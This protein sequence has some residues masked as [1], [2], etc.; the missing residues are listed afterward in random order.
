MEQ[1]IIGLFQEM[2][3]LTIALLSAGMLLCIF[4][5]FVPKVGLTG[6]LGIA[7]LCTGMSSYYIDGFKLNQLLGMLSIIALLLAVFIVIE[8]ILEAKG[9]IKNPNR[10]KLR[11]YQD[12][13]KHLNEL[14][15]SIGKAVTNIDLGGTIEIDGKLYY[16]ISDACIASGSV[17]QIIGVQNNA[18]VV[19]AY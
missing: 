13:N 1:Y 12:D 7:L 8:L 10:Y 2:S 15:G 5:V 11:T 16:V 3:W 6:I 19:K 14:V 18:L 9:V 4:E 17:V